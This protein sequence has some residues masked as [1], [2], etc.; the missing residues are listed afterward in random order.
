[1]PNDPIRPNRADSPD[2]QPTIVFADSHWP[3][4][5]DLALSTSTGEVHSAVAIE[6]HADGAATFRGADVHGQPVTL[7]FTVEEVDAWTKGVADGEFD[8][9]IVNETHNN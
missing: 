9:L 3:A 1:M 4:V 7:E 8:L 5:R 2:R 6:L